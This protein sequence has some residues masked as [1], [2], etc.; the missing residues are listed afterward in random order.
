MKLEGG[1]WGYFSSKVSPTGKRLLHLENPR[2]VLI[3]VCGMNQPLTDT[4][5]SLPYMLRTIP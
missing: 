1:H 4:K 5:A 3:E 2:S